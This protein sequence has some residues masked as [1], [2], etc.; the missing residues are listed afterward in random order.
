MTP[1]RLEPAAPRSRVKHSATEPLRSPYLICEQLRRT[2]SFTQ[3]CC[4]I[5]LHIGKTL[6]AI[7]TV[8]E[9]DELMGIL[10]FTNKMV[11]ILARTLSFYMTFCQM[12][13]EKNIGIP[14]IM[15]SYRDVLY[16]W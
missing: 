3:S 16:L 10:K 6:F 15:D 2:C 9:L 14:N 7:F 13:H 5:R 4:F 12:N 11:I 1:M 8:H